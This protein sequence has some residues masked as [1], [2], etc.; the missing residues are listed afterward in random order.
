MLDTS[1]HASPAFKSGD[2]RGLRATLSVKWV[3]LVDKEVWFCGKYVFKNCFR[4][5]FSQFGALLWIM[6]TVLHNYNPH[7]FFLH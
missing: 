2:K 6:I 4:G 3:D 5:S 7:T 1:T